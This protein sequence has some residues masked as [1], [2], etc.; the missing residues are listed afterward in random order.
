MI[1]SIIYHIFFV[2][3]TYTWFTFILSIISFFKWKYSIFRITLL[4]ICIIALVIHLI[5]YLQILLHLNLL[6]VLD[7]ILIL[8]IHIISFNFI[9][10]ILLKAFNAIFYFILR[11]LEFFYFLLGHLIYN[12]AVVWRKG[13]SHI[14]CSVIRNWPLSDFELLQRGRVF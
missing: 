1:L 12:F 4:N 7:I 3:L 6:L 14:I 9:F 5:S 10:L 8:M 2:M 11:F 13:L